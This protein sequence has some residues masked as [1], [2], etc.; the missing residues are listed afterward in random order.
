MEIARLK[1]RDIYREAMNNQKKEIREVRVGLESKY[2][3][4]AEKCKRL[5]L[6][7]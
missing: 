5:K 4:L 3:V 2:K 1:R 6:L 7:L